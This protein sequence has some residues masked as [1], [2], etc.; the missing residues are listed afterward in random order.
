MNTAIGHLRLPD[1]LMLVGYFVLMLFIGVYFYRYMRGMKDY[2]RGGNTIPWWLSGVSFYMSSFSVAAFVF[3]PSLCYRYGWVG[4][5]LLWVAVPATMFSAGIFAKRWRRT[6]IDSPVEYVETR[7]GATL[8]QLFA[9]QGVPVRIIDDGIKLVATGKFVSICTGLPMSASILGAGGIMLLYTFMGGL[10]AV[11][12]TDFIQFIVLSAGVIIILPLSIGRAGGLGEIFSK[13]PDGFFRLTSAEFGWSYLIPLVLLYA[14]A[15]SSINWTLIQRYYC[16]PR[17]RDA[18][19]VGGLVVALYIIGPPLM[20]F[21]AIAATRFIPTLADAGD[22]YP[23]LCAQ[24]FPAGMLGLAIAAMFAATMS[25]L[26]GDYNVCASVLT[27]DVY[28]RLLRPQAS[29]RELV[30]V[31]R[32]MTLVI[33]IIALGAATLIA[34]GKAENLFRI[35]VTLFGVATAPVAVPMLLGLLSRRHTNASAIGGFLLGIGTGLGLFFF[36]RY[37]PAGEF[38][39]F[40]W[41]PAKEEVAVGGFALKMEIVLFLSTAVITLVTMEVVSLIQRFL[42]PVS[43]ARQQQIDAFLDRLGTPIGQ[44]ADDQ[45]AGQESALSPFWIVGICVL[46]IGLMM[47]AVIPWAIGSVALWIDTFLSLLLIVIGIVLMRISPKRAGE[48]KISV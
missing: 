33:G 9:W 45:A 44:L 30:N 8:R 28:R 32:I 22:I 10:W 41:D 35:M 37:A 4:I 40:S 2:F 7:F 21:P 12:V 34:R 14:L 27:N 48:T 17:E 46:A 29:Q 24:L 38:L 15:W 47:L 18:L 25:T 19:K 26:S 11:A 31:G 13:A 23:T 43:A 42:F 16:V 6:R 39:G 20:F 36:S 1:Y 3:Y 5:T